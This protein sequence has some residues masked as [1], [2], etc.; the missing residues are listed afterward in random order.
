M[1]DERPSADWMAEDELELLANIPTASQRAASD[2]QLTMRIFRDNAP[3]AAEII[4][5]LAAN[6]LKESTRLAASKY[7][8]DRVLGR[9][10]EAIP[11][12]A[13]DPWTDLFGSVVREPTADERK[14]GSRVSRL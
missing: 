3:V 8:V 12:A 1:P 14:N 6:G 13:N 2:E 11:T 5:H 9:I 7:I 4:A 10:G